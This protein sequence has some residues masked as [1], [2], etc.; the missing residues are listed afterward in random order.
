MHDDDHDILI[1]VA[2][3]VRWLRESYEDH[4]R[5]HWAVTLACIVCVLATVG[6]LFITIV[7]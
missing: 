4:R 2:N 6:S 5:H 7:T 1:Q 3:D